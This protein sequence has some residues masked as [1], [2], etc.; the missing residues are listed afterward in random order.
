MNAVLTCENA[1]AADALWPGISGELWIFPDRLT[2]NGGPGRCR[3]HRLRGLDVPGGA[4]ND[5]M[6][7]PSKPTALSQFPK[8]VLTRLQAHPWAEG[9]AVRFSP[10]PIG[11]L[12]T[13]TYVRRTARGHEVDWRGHKLHVTYVVPDVACIQAPADGMRR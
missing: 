2:A 8:D 9:E 6:P 10:S 3:Q 11:K 7:E 1:G 12:V 13:G 4:V 5:S